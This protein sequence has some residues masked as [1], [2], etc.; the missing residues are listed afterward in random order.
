M[1]KFDLQI[2][3]LRIRIG[4]FYWS[5]FHVFDSSNFERKQA[6]EE[7]FFPSQEEME[8]REHPESG[9]QFDGSESWWDGDV[10]V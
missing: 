7:I 6:G 5:M 4:E 3:K 1:K 2:K 8:T 10:I 9:D